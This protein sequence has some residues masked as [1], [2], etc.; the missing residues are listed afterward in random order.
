MSEERTYEDVTTEEITEE[1]MEEVVEEVVEEQPVYDAPEGA[2]PVYEQAAPQ[3]PKKAKKGFA[4]ACLVFGIFAFITTLFLVNY[5]FGL[6]SLIFGIIYLAKKADIKPKGKAIAGI[7]LTVISLVVSTTIWVSA[8][9]YF[10]KTDVYTI[11]EDFGTMMGEEIDGRETVNQ[12]VVE[13]TGN[14]MDLNTIEEFVGGEVTVERMV[15]FVG[16]VKEEEITEFVN[17]VSTMD[18]A[19]IQ[20]L[21]QEFGGEVTYEKLEEKL[22]KDFTLRELM[23]YIDKNAT[24]VPQQ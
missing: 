7:V 16:D 23:E 4:T 15:N 1:V 8:Y 2:A 22:G 10:V 12:M 24:T 21:I 6:L 11:M 13:A 3:E 19:S 18:E 17:K 20:N 5:V 14:M 9:M